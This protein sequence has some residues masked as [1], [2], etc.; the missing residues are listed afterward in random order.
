[1][2]IAQAFQAIRLSVSQ[3][4]NQSLHTSKDEIFF[5]DGDDDDEMQRGQ[6]C[7]TSLSL[8]LHSLK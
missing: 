6:L 3:S 1:M 7:P 8:L 2:Q 5:N 4:V